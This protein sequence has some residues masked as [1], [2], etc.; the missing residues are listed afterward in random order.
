MSHTVSF[1]FRGALAIVTDVGNGMQWTRTR[2]WR[3]ARAW[4]VKSCGPDA[5]TLASSFAE[6]DFHEATVTGAGAAD[7]S[8]S[9]K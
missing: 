4:T 7:I 5:S 8:A 2:A 9:N 3:N 1:P 6:R